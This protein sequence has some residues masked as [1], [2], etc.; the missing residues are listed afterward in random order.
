MFPYSPKTHPDHATLSHSDIIN[1]GLFHTLRTL[2]IRANINRFI[3]ST[4]LNKHYQKHI[5]QSHTHTHTHTHTYIYIYIYIHQSR[6]YQ[7]L[8]TI[9]HPL[10]I[11]LLGNSNNQSW[12][13]YISN[14]R[15]PIQISTVQRKEQYVMDHLSKFHINQTVN[16]PENA[17]FWKLCKLM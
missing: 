12:V 7:H 9:K 2:Y 6:S 15:Y 16:E 13:T 1:S 8:S 3:Y 4:W 5:H 17:V 10:L 11:I 14:Y